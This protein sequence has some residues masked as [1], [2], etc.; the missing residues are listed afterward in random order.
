MM[1]KKEKGINFFFRFFNQQS[2]EN[3]KL[4]GTGKGF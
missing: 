4:E 1:K 3:E 2:M